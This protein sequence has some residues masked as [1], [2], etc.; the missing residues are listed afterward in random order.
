MKAN[1]FLV[2][3]VFLFLFHLFAQT[4]KDSDY[5][6]VETVA[7]VVK[8]SSVIRVYTV[9]GLPDNYRYR[10]VG[11]EPDFGDARI[12]STEDVFV[13]VGT[14]VIVTES[15]LIMTN[16][17]VYGAYI[18]PEILEKKNDNGQVIGEEKGRLGKCSVCRFSCR[19][20]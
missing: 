18:E 15:G 2:C 5:I 16:A 17:H 12:L 20:T 13:H 9:D 1:K 11:G 19:A 4:S 10:T 7:S 3:I 14:G 6:S 8:L